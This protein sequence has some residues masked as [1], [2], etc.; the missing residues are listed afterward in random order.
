MTAWRRRIYDAQRA[1]L[2]GV[3]RTITAIS[4]VNTVL[5]IYA[6]AG[7]RAQRAGRERRSA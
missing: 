3:G 5:A 4:A 7:S 6:N 1:A 2:P